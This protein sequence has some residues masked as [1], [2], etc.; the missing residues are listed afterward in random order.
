MI[1]AHSILV[2][3]LQSEYQEFKANNICSKA[4]LQSPVVA[5]AR[6][7]GWR[8]GRRGEGEGLQGLPGSGSNGCVNGEAGNRKMD[9]DYSVIQSALFVC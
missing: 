4:S 7:G 8:G 2:R 9:I 5:E 6:G 1:G 3:E